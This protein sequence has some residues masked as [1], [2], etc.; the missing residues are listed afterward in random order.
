MERILITGGSG[1]IGTNLIDLYENREK[2]EAEGNVKLLNIDIKEPRNSNHLKYWKRASILDFQPLQIIIQDFNPTYIYHLAAKTDLNSYNISEYS[3]NTTGLKN[4]IEVCR[5]LVDLKRIIF[6]SSRLVC[7]IGYQPISDS[8]YCPTTAYGESK[9]VGENIVRDSMLTVPWLIVR[10][11]SIW[12]PWF[13]VPYKKFF[14]SISKSLYVHPGNL[15]IYKSFGYVG[16]SVFLLDRLM[17][18]STE[19]VNKKIFYLADY[20]PINV[21]DMANK[22]QEC[23]GTFPIKTVSIGILRFIATIGD[24]LQIIGVK[25]PPLT[26]FRLDNLTTNMIHDL[27]PLEK[28]AGTLP[29]SFDEGIKLTCSWLKR[30]Y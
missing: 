27:Q 30:E 13:D 1:F 3:A 21:R 4:L 16:N 7:R 6:A 23:M 20:E 10:P 5:D 18:C 24:I 11:T 19:L 28:V 8:D 12:G 9:V 15:N 17:F 14:D 26:S 25:N 2:H 22:I 29:Y